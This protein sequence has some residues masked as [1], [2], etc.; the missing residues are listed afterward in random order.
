VRGNATLHAGYVHIAGLI[1]SNAVITADRITIAPSAIING[2]LTYTA[3]SEDSLKI[4]A[5]AAVKG[6]ISWEPPEVDERETTYTRLILRIAS[7]LASF[8]FGIMVV[9]LFRPYAEESFNQLYNRF[10]VSSAAGLVGLI[11]FFLCLLVLLISLLFLTAG[12]LIIVL[13]SEM[14][15]LGMLFLVFSI[16]MIPITSF[17][18]ITGGIILYSGV[19]VVAYLI[20]HLIA[21][22]FRPT[23]R[24]LSA[25]SLFIGLVLLLVLFSVPYAGNI[26]YVAGTIIGAG[27]ILNGIRHC[28]REKLPSG[29]ESASETPGS[30]VSKDQ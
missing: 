29:S 7:M 23:A 20:G 28:R 19:I 4:A 26:L 10:A 24:P 14:T 30:S 17:T 16:L 1:D 13:S 27:A 18:G 5:G 12:L 8:I 25:G 6:G 22:L 2:S 3:E 21:R 15:G 9:R 11:C